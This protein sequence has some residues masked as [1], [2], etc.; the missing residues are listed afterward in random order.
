MGLLI[1]LQNG[2][3][4]LKSLKFGKD[5]PGGGDS[6]Q[7]FIE[8]SIPLNSENPQIFNDFILRG[9]I[10]APLSAAEDVVRLTRYFF[11]LKSPSGLLFTAKQNLLSRVGS[12]TEA[13]KG[14]GY[15]GGGLNEGIYTP[16]ST[17]LQA[18]TGFLGFHYPKQGLNLTSGTI[19]SY[20]EAI[21][22]N[23]FDGNEFIPKNNRLLALK[24][25]IQ[26]KSPVFNFSSI[27]NYNLNVQ[28]SLITYQGGPDSDIGVGNTRINFST[29]NFGVSIKTLTNNSSSLDGKKTFNQEDQTKWYLPLEASINYSLYDPSSLS[30][31]TNEL[32][33]TTSSY[34]LNG[35]SSKLPKIE[36]FD[37]TNIIYNENDSIS[38]KLRKKGYI[39]AELENFNTSNGKIIVTNRSSSEI[40]ASLAINNIPKSRTYTEIY[41]SRTAAGI[42]AYNKGQY[43]ID[44][45]SLI[46][47]QITVV[48]P[49]FPTTGSNIS[50][51]AYI[52]TLSDSYGADWSPQIYMGRAEKFWKYNTFSRDIN[53]GFTV[54]AE[55]EFELNAMYSKLNEL[56]A[57]LAPTYTSAGYMAG[58]LHRL[59]IG[60]YVVGQ[61]GIMTSLTYDVMED[62]PWE[63][64]PG[65]QVPHYIKV[66][67]IKFTPIHNWR[68]ES[69]FN[70]EHNYIKQS[71]GTNTSNSGSI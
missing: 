54:V 70:T 51:K 59:T 23:Q 25:S 4:Q 48:N 68:P 17:L 10:K 67:G 46:P 69:W 20:T 35:T 2:D 36:I 60:N 34:E 16:E 64:T 49:R 56:A 24:D 12:K 63:I 5:R 50:F 21:K 66:S 22:Q 8:T 52:D 7:P 13:S 33:K 38:L 26:Q 41:N 1:K 32:L 57:S 11:S 62:S 19:I 43:S 42:K 61:Y 55:N 6:G 3:T 14:P 45:N 9:G 27:L 30:E 47:F 15:A 39:N 40:S 37:D 29:D 28:D 44:N 18:G 31:L 53:F 58:N 65:N 71:A